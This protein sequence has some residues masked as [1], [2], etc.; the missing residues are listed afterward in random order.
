VG[1][2]EKEGHVFEFNEL[3]FEK[4]LTF[5]R[6]DR[7]WTR[8]RVLDIFLESWNPVSRWWVGRWMYPNFFPKLQ[9]YELRELT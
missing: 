8:K 2:P 7:T 1:W 5:T 3:D 9:Y 6:A 4:M